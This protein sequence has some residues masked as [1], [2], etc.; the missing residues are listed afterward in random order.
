MYSAYY[1]IDVLNDKQ[2]FTGGR[3]NFLL[4]GPAPGPPAGY[5]PGNLYLLI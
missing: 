5:G 2:P 4:G 1:V 3:P